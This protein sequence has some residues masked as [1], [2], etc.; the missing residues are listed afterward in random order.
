MPLKDDQ[1]KK[2]DLLREE[3]DVLEIGGNLN[4]AARR[5]PDQAAHVI[6]LADAQ[7]KTIAT[8][9]DTGCFFC[10]G[11]ANLPIWSTIASEFK[12]RQIS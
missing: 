12:T 2:L 4:R 10:S 5:D 3:A 8:R 9:S 1:R 7:Y 11:W 6:T